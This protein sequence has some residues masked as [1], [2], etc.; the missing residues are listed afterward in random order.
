MGGG[1][2]TYH[3]KSSSSHKRH[4]RS[5]HEVRERYGEAGTKA[6]SIS[7]SIEGASKD[8]IIAETRPSA[9]EPTA[10]SP[11]SV[12]KD[13][14]S[15]PTDPTSPNYPDIPEQDWDPTDDED[16]GKEYQT[17]SGG[18]DDH[19]RAPN[20]A[21]PS[22][23]SFSEPSTLLPSGNASDLSII[24]STSD[25]SNLRHSSSSAQQPAT[26]SAAFPLT[27][28]GPSPA[29]PTTVAQPVAL[30]HSKVSSFC[31]NVWH[32]QHS[33]G[34]MQYG[35]QSSP[36]KQMNLLPAIE[37]Q[38]RRPPNEINT[39]IPPSDNTAPSSPLSG[40]SN[41]PVDPPP[42]TIDTP[43]VLTR[44]PSRAPVQGKKPPPPNLNVQLRN[45]TEGSFLIRL[46]R[47][48]PLPCTNPGPASTQPPLI[49]VT[50]THDSNQH[51]TLTL[52]KNN[53]A[54][55]MKR[56]KNYTLLACP[57]N[58]VLKPQTP[59]GNATKLSYRLHRS[60]QQQSIKCD[61]RCT[62][63]LATCHVVCLADTIVGGSVVHQGKPAYRPFL[64]RHYPASKIFQEMD[65]GSRQDESIALCS[66]CV[67]PGSTIQ[68]IDC[69][70]T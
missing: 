21:Q 20:I 52:V 68:A 8:T 43:L 63:T 28:I 56:A 44:A 35:T 12:T 27:T 49:L 22:D 13:E 58:G 7:S 62:S 64:R 10:P 69:M 23:T 36:P 14:R 26:F 46:R 47:I 24:P 1:E 11:A 42:Q 18:N 33:F 15:P 3:V 17:P 25:R 37:V 60:K 48:A 45:V 34:P 5:Q 31:F 41:P 61:R 50:E 39:T 29:N 16:G 30:V 40:T 32:C 53:C 9:S 55:I 54:Q 59:N 66:D 51:S 6:T 70:G 67:L 19:Q 4:R 2:R 57:T 38:F 65:Q